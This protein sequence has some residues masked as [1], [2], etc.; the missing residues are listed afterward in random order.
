MIRLPLMLAAVAVAAPAHAAPLDEVRAHLAAIRTM[1]AEFTQTAE[2]GQVLHGKLIL[3]KPGRVRLQ[4]DKAPILVVGDGRFVNFVD[5]EVDQV[6][7][8]PIRGTPLGILLDPTIDVSAFARVVDAPTGQIAIEA[9]DPKHPEYGVTTL[10]F[11]RDSAA[12]AG[13]R[14]AGWRVMDAQGHRTNVDLQDLRF[15]IPVDSA[16]FRFRDPRRRNLP[17]KG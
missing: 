5:Y 6:T 2:G 1:T 10:R 9:R 14:L 17:G 16:S 12:P 4:F 3:Q 7:T 11:A 15:N 13:L 8:Y